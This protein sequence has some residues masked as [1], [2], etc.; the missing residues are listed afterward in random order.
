M[1]FWVYSC[2]Q[3]RNTSAITSSLA[4]AAAELEKHD[5]VEQKAFCS[6]WIRGLQA[7]PFQEPD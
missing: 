1:V 6:E 3:A 4:R 5:V 7:N 2:V